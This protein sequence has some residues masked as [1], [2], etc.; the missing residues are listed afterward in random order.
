MSFCAQDWLPAQCS[1]EGHIPGGS[2]THDQGWAQQ[3]EPEKICPHNL[4]LQGTAS[5]TCLGS[6]QGAA[7]KQYPEKKATLPA[8]ALI[9]YTSLYL[10]IPA[11]IPHPLLLPVV[12]GLP[13]TC[14]ASEEP[15]SLPKAW[16]CWTGAP[17]AVKG[18]AQRHRQRAV[19]CIDQGCTWDLC[20]GI[21]LILV[22]AS[23]AHQ[24]VF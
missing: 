20:S 19:V 16:S 6:F 10:L 9:P 11:Y 18:K 21:E 17:V 13:T 5:P 15:C 3:G 24:R 14:S 23:H 8:P 2:L 4:L 12:T 1:Q 7:S 22:L